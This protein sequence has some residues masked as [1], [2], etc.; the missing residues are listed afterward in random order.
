MKF[1][2]KH[3][4]WFFLL[5]AFFFLIAFPSSIA[6]AVR[7]IMNWFTPDVGAIYHS[8]SIIDILL[9]SISM[10]FGFLFGVI[11]VF[12]SLLCWKTE[13][14]KYMLTVVGA[15]W[16]LTLLHGISMH[17][18][19][20]FMY[21]DFQIM[22][23]LQYFSINAFPFLLAFYLLIIPFLK[24]R[25]PVIP[26]LGIFLILCVCGSLMFAQAESVF[27]AIQNILQYLF[28]LK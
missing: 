3:K 26:I 22:T 12:T 16:L 28:L 27:Y 14:G 15:V 20:I 6:S 4:K 10:I 1:L 13:K 9:N 21:Q 19:V 2:H 8:E 18:A 24:T 11:L 25:G 7:L 23:L 17:I 5:S